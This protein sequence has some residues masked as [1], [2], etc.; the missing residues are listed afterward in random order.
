M[1]VHFAKEAHGGWDTESSSH[2]VLHAQITLQSL[3]WKKT[4]LLPMLISAAWQKNRYAYNGMEGSR[5]GI[6]DNPAVLEVSWESSY[7]TYDNW[8][9]CQVHGIVNNNR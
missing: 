5:W 8:T 9:L 3:I 1:S 6:N 2:L 7:M 4:G